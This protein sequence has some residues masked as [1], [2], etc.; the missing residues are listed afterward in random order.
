MHKVGIYYKQV[1]DNSDKLKSPSYY[2]N[3]LAVI[4]REAGLVEQKRQT[5]R[6]AALVIEDYL[7]QCFGFTD[8]EMNIKL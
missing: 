7:K 4:E 3:A 8:E 2:L 6:E 5:S 1:I